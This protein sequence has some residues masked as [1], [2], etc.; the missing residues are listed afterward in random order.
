M[1]R[2]RSLWTVFASARG[3]TAALLAA[4]A[5]AGL[6]P[7]VHAASDPSGAHPS[8]VAPGG[9]TLWG[10]LELL[11]S[12]ERR[13]VQRA[14][15]DAT[16]LVGSQ[17]AV[18]LVDRVPRRTL[19]T[20][21]EET[22]TRREMAEKGADAILLVVAVHDRKAVIETDKGPAALVP[23][24]D[25]RGIVAR[26]THELS[27]SN[28]AGRLSMACRAIVA[29]ARA[30]RQR[31]RPLPPDE[32]A[33]RAA[34]DGAADTGA[35]PEAPAVVIPTAASGEEP[36][37]SDAPVS[38][39]S[40]SRLP[41]AIAASVLFLVSLGLYKRRQMSSL[42]KPPLPPPREASPRSGGD[43]GPRPP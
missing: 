27:R 18:L 21:A 42:R 17:V 24:I 25:A 36:P 37:A 13:D 19:S 10:D 1:W 5:L 4:T 12:S 20:L 9:S 35:H 11:S 29:S 31:R 26:L 14:L 2:A 34:A 43:D 33:P 16:R 38:P 41:L 23:E 7:V 22:F 40:R 30:T 3:P 32:P 15:D 8:P 39:R 6:A 28:L